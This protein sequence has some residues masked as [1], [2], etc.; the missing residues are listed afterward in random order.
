MRNVLK[1]GDRQGYG[2]TMIKP[3][4][5]MILALGLALGMTTAQ[6]DDYIVAV[7]P[8]F[9]ADQAARVY[10]PLLDYLAQA[11]GHRFTLHVPQNYHAMW[12]EIRTDRAIDFA[13]EDAHFADYR[14]QRFGFQPLAR[15]QEPTRF[16]L[17][18]QPH[19]ADDGA[20][21]LVGS[22]V[23][24]MPAPSLGSA[25]L[26]SVYPNPIAQPEFESSAASWR[27]GVEMV[28]A[29]EAEGAMVP[30]FIAEL[31][32]NLVSVFESPEFP[33]RTVLASPM[34]PVEVRESVREALL[35]LS[36]DGDLYELLAELGISGFQPADAES[37]DGQD[38]ILRAFFGFQPRP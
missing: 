7:E 5:T 22:R 32:P 26:A 3:T 12:R 20:M 15:T 31:Y 23:V 28:F 19:L 34:V 27:D 8:S 11:T 33:G 2:L 9:P 1:Y 37:I 30:S 16:H 36:P 6:A 35:A 25:M 24:T 29:D 17:I 14:I 21:G 10:Q 18:V 4:G 38:E 13:L